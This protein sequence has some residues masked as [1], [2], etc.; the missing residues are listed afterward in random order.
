MKGFLASPAPALRERLLSGGAWALVG[1]T[2][3][4]FS[5]VAINALLARLLSPQDLGTYFLAF[6]VISLGSVAGWLGLDQAGVR[7]VAE[8]LGLG[9]YRRARQSVGK[10]VW[11]GLLGATGVGLAYLLVGDLIGERLF[12]SPALVAVTGLVAAWMAITSLQSLVAST[13]RGFHDIRLAAVFGASVSGIG[14]LP[15]GL[16]VL[17]LGF[18]LLLEGSSSLALVLLLAILAGITSAL[19]AGLMLHRK[20]AALPP[21]GEDDVRAS[22]MLRVAWPLLVTNLTLFA[23]TQVDIWILGAFRSSEEVAVYGAA[24]RVVLLVAMPLQIMNAVV[25]PLIAEMYAQGRERALERTLRPMAT[26]AG[27]PAL[28]VLVGFILLGGPLLGL[29]YGEYFSAGARVLVLLSVGQIVSVWV[30]SCAITLAM[31]GRQALL[32][33]ITL[34]CG[35]ATVLAGLALVGGYGSEG[36]A[37]AAAGGLAL[38][39]LLLW[40]AARYAIGIWTHLGFAALPGFIKSV[41]RDA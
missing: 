3:A 38:Q 16:M 18:V 28:V 40:L 19:T 9:E 31:T 15:G 32:M 7:F 33:G 29:V 25:P 4:A 39:N 17:S 6:S 35:V 2:G 37:V 24:A 8:S 30:G 11:F 14:L 27:I 34:S 10:V 22:E 20:T 21:R 12:H 13:F 1:R 26:L 5:Q 23:I 41:A 36:V